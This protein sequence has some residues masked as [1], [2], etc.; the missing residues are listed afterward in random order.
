MSDSAEGNFPKPAA[1]TAAKGDGG[2][3]PA[4]L[5]PED[6]DRIASAFVPSWQFDEAPFTA[7]AMNP[8]D[9][10][11]LG[12]SSGVNSDR[13]IVDPATKPRSEHDDLTASDV[14]VSNLVSKNV[15]WWLG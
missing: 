5:A 14:D 12:A 2:G 11:E 6:A 15:V 10:E 9:L 4:G 8:A 7:G 3:Q 1:G 13:T